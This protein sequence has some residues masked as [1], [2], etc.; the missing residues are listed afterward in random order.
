MFISIYLLIGGGL[1][2]SAFSL[3]II[4]TTCSR[5]AYHFFVHDFF[6]IDLRHA[7]SFETLVEDVGSNCCDE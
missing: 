6:E 1:W 2:N 3:L 7:E 5:S 4:A